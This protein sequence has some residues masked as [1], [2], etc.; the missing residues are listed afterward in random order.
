MDQSNAQVAK[1][2]QLFYEISASRPPLYRSFVVTL[3]EVG[4]ILGDLC[5]HVVGSSTLFAI[6]QAAHPRRQKGCLRENV[7]FMQPDLLMNQGKPVFHPTGH[8]R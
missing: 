7:H 4:Q 6:D 1:L 5:Q 8:T 3:L 2:E